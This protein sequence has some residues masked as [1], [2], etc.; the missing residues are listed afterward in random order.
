MSTHLQMPW[1]W[2]AACVLI[3]TI[4]A[5]FHLYLDEHEKLNRIIAR[6]HFATTQAQIAMLDLELRARYRVTCRWPSH[7]RKAL[8]IASELAVIRQQI[9]N[10]ETS[11]C[12]RPKN[13]S[14]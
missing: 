10:L 1:I 4:I 6:G 13:I 5:L 7:K 12:F 11:P 8:K 2:A 14:P 9:R 3:G